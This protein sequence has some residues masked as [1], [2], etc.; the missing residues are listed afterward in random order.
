MKT[1]DTLHRT[2]DYSTFEM[3]PCNRPLRE[4]PWLEASM[5]KHGFMPSCPMHCIRNGH[6][7]LKII[8]G[9]HRFHYAKRLGLPVFYIIDASNIDLFELEGAS[10]AL[11]SAVDH[12]EARARAGNP[13]YLKLLDFKNKHRLTIAVAA[14]LVG[15]EGAGSHNFG[16]KLKE[17]TFKVGG[18]LSHANKVVR[19]TDFC[20]KQGVGFARTGSFVSAVSLV[21]HVPEFNPEIFM[22][23][24][25]LVGAQLRKR[26]TATDYLDEIEALY[27]YGAKSKRIAVA[28]QAKELARKRSVCNITH[29]PSAPPNKQAS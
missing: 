10:D 14:S 1:P 29:R 15:G 21:L 23:R 7:K 8:R 18:D 26:A 16:R 22:H 20:H 25:S 24:V 13:D 6:G 11:W 9:H 19:I 17:G 5:K 4:K 12:T 3:H 2:K 27:N 28:F